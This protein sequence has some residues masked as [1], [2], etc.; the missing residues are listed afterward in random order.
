MGLIKLLLRSL[1]MLLTQRSSGLECTGSL[2]MRQGRLFC[3]HGSP[4]TPTEGVEGG[5][6]REAEQ[7]VEDA[8][9]VKQRDDRR[10][11]LE[12]AKRAKV[13]ESEQRRT[14]LQRAQAAARVRISEQVAARR[15]RLA[16]PIR[17]SDPDATYQRAVD[18]LADGATLAAVATLQRSVQ[19]ARPTDSRA[20]FLLA[21]VLMLR[22][23][24][25]AAMRVAALLASPPRTTQHVAAT[26]LRESLA[27][28][29][30]L[31]SDALEH[32]K[33]GNAAMVWQIASALL[34]RCN[35]A[36]SVYLLR[37]RSALSLSQFALLRRDA[38]AAV[39][40]QP[41]DGE[42]FLLLAVSMWRSVPQSGSH[43]LA[44]VRWCI[45]LEPE[46]NECRGR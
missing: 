32:Q 29:E 34:V 27:D 16:R 26:E 46:H 14:T 38:V 3:D 43:A 42:G 1:C 25:K 17:R 33:T 39:D 31:W 30:M 12:A 10:A 7:M 21:R 6:Q 8:A 41:W 36:A 20:R 44:A 24:L 13:Q 11:W 4:D 45:R 28:A 9:V 22:G 35:R 2:T 19:L 15:S 37:A 5:W 40:L 23:E 18:L